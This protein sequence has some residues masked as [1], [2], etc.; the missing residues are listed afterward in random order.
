MAFRKGNLGVKDNNWNFR[1][2]LPSL[3][4]KDNEKVVIFISKSRLKREGGIRLEFI[5]PG[6]GIEIVTY[7]GNYIPR[8]P[9]PTH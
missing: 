7:E 2:L 5:R 3:F 8:P 4:C 9:P 1:F 6:L